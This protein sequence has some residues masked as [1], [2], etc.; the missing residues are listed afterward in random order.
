MGRLRCCLIGVWN[1]FCTL[2]VEDRVRRVEMVD[3]VCEEEII[4]FKSKQD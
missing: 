4:M 1:D 3:L 2:P